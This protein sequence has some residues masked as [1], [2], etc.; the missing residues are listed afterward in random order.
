[1]ICLYTGAPTKHRLTQLCLSQSTSMV[2]TNRDDDSIS[3]ISMGSC[4]NEA[5][6][7]EAACTTNGNWAEDT[8]CGELVGGRELSSEACE[9]EPATWDA[10]LSVS[11]STCSGPGAAAL[12]GDTFTPFVDRTCTV[13]VDECAS[14][15]CR[16]GGDCMDSRDS[17]V[18]ALGVYSCNC[19]AG[20]EGDNCAEDVNE[21]ASHP[22]HY[23]VCSADNTDDG[24]E[25]YTCTCDDGW[26]G[27]HC[28][29]DIDECRSCHSET[30]CQAVS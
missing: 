4:E 15:P 14:S 26:E 28:D 5:Y 13:D 18:Y 1:M 30:Q 3:V 23:G 12:L 10:A 6:S 29:I 24:L 11:I 20:W 9:A 27:D 16:N 25:E 19:L 22:C 7:T 17:A 2:A 8:L 21:C